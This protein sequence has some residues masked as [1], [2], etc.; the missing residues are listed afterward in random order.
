MF[1]VL[2]LLAVNGYILWKAPNS[3]KPKPSTNKKTSEKQ[4]GKYVVYGTMS[5]KWT[6]EQ[7]DYMKQKNIP[8]EFVDCEKEPEKCKGLPGFPGIKFPDGTK[9]VG[10]TEV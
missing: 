8:Y 4:E 1:P 10:Y 5:C 7:L 3:T 6:R 2:L 9:K